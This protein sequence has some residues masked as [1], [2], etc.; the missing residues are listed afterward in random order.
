MTQNKKR[1]LWV[2]AAFAML[3]AVVAGIVLLT[4]PQGV[5]GEK[6]IGLTVVFADG[7]QQQYDIQT[8]AAYLGEA[9]EQEGL[10]EGEQ[11]QYGLYITTV[12]GVT[13]DESKE[14]WWCLTQ[15]G[16]ALSTG[17]DSTP[18]SDDDQFELTLTVGYGTW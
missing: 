18:I 6:Q 15:N 10:I 3:A 14:E 12:C 7:A 4:G 13:A 2:V 8:D 16:G 9:L 5:A 1:T 17:A 11:A